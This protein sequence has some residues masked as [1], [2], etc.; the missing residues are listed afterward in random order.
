MAKSLTQTASFL[1][2]TKRSDT[3][4]IALVAILIV[5]AAAAGIYLGGA[6][7]SKST[8]T[9]TSSGT[10]SV[11][12]FQIS[13]DTLTVGYKGGLFQLGFQDT[14]GK[15]IQGVVTV[16][17]TP[18][19]AVLC[20]GYTTGL[21]FT[22]CLPGPGKSYTFTVPSGGSFPADSSFSGFDSGVGPG[23][24][25]GGQNYTLS[26]KAWYTDGTTASENFTVPAVLGA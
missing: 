11:K 5:G 9:S 6:S 12:A 18:V 4:L 22:N 15:P 2:F 17:Y 25:A 13:Y 19:Q 10:A 21:G 3:L 24:A 16:L 20:S 23:S 26:I 7:H 14:T 8:S 1:R